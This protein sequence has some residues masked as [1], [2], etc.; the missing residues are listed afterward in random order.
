MTHTSY[1]KNNPCYK[2]GKSIKIKGIT[3]HSVGCPQPNAQA[4]IDYWGQ[5]TAKV[6][7]HAIIDGLTGE[8]YQTLPW[9]MRAW[10][11]GSGPKGSYNNDHI[12]VEMCEPDCIKYL[13]GATFTCSNKARAKEIAKRT[14]KAAV[15]LFA[16]LCI[17]Y[18]LNPLGDGVIVSHSEAHARG[19]ASGHADPEHLWNQLGLSYNMDKFRKAVKKA[20]DEIAK[21]AFNPYLVRVTR[22]TLS[23]RDG[24]SIL[25]K[26][27]MTVKKNETFTIVEEKNG[28]GRLLSGAGWIKLKYIEKV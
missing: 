27:N 3:L 26:K 13:Y 6:C 12:S 11:C 15:S 16:D 7:V 2:A 18:D 23:V 10:H 5:P 25:F 4:F 17:R 24:A 9:E 28:Y 1:L 21:K 14:Y 22:D 8:V 19:Y 20:V